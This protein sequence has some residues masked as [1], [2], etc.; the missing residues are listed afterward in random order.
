MVS[1]IRLSITD[2]THGATAE[3]VFVYAVVRPVDPGAM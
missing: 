3:S 2:M 1:H